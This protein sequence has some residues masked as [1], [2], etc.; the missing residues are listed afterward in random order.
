[1]NTIHN[2]Y[3]CHADECVYLEPLAKFS[4]TTGL[5]GVLPLFSGIV[6]IEVLV[7]GRLSHGSVEPAVFRRFQGIGDPRHV[8]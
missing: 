6:G 3:K 1:M 8:R 4:I 5:I 2:F 7:I